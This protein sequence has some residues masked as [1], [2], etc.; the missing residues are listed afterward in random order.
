MRVNFRISLANYVVTTL[1][2]CEESLKVITVQECE[3]AYFKVAGI[4]I[5]F[6][7]LLDFALPRR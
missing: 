4:P 1:E 6:R 3:R 2:V 7:F 5:T